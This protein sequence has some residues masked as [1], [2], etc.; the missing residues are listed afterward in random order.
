MKSAAFASY[1]LDFTTPATVNVSAA[2]FISQTAFTRMLLRG[3]R[4]DVD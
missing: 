1:E 3:S 2:A 4:A